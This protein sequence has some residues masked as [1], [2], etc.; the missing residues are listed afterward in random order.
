[1]GRDDEEADEAAEECEENEE[2]V[3]MCCPGPHAHGEASELAEK[4]KK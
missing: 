3:E 4:M 2:C 1:M